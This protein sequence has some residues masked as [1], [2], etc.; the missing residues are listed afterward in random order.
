MK[1]T[2]AKNSFG[3]GL[4]TDFVNANKSSVYDL[5]IPDGDF[6]FDTSIRL[7]PT[8]AMAGVNTITF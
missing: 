2:K 7:I 1:A 3:D 4:I 6:R 5:N 8:A